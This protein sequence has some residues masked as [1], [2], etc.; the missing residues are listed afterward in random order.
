MYS[1]RDPVFNFELT[2][3]QSSVLRTP[4]WSR[5]IKNLSWKYASQAISVPIILDP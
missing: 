3:L 1:Q 5:C 4:C 2:S